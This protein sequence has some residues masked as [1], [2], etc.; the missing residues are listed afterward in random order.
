MINR[1]ENKIIPPPIKPS[2]GFKDLTGIRFGHCLAIYHY[3]TE[4]V[5]T[6]SKGVMKKKAIW[7]CRCDC[8]NEFLVRGNSLKTNKTTSCGCISRVRLIQYNVENKTKVSYNSFSDVYKSYKRGAKQRGL[9]F[10][11]TKEEF[12]ELA[13]GNC[14]YCGSFPNKFRKKRNI[15]KGDIPEF[16]HNGVDRVDNEIGYYMSNCVSCC[17]NCNRMKRSLPLSEFVLHVRKIYKHLRLD[18]G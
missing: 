7:L 17:T 3:G 11:L 13:T 18:I 4:L 10:K 2:N 1:I 12:L 16:Y 8:G 14:N 5:G 15:N 6:D 9:E